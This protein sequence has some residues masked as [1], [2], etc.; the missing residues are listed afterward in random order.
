[1]KIHFYYF[2]IGQNKLLIS[3][4]FQITH[5]METVSKIWIE[6]GYEMFEK[7][8]R[9]FQQI[10]YKSREFP[11]FVELCLLVFQILSDCINLN[12]HTY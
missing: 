4:D 11:R 12:K 8:P 5:L 9:L 2:H 1:M 3:I 6:K 10:Q 7:E